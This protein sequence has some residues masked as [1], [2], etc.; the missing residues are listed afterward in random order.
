MRRR[1][2][3]RIHHHHPG[4]ARRMNETKRVL[5]T[6]ASGGIGSAIARALGA[7][8]FELGLHY[9]RNAEAA[10]A[11]AADIEQAGGR[12]HTLGFDIADRG[13]AREALRS[14]ERRV[15]KEWKARGGPMSTTSKSK[16][17]D[18]IVTRR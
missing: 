8:G 15:G 7:A 6:G 11:L 17:L 16:K 9:R 3:G 1:D 14:E 13:A 10:Q 18:E 5:I 12:A 4:G 2:P